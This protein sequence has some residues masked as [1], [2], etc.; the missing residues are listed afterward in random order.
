MFFCTLQVQWEYQA[1]SGLYQPYP[2]EINSNLEK[3]Q[4]AGKDHVEWEKEEPDGKVKRWMV[5]LKQMLETDGQTTKQI[6]RKVL[7]EKGKYQCK[8]RC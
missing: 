4:K 6:K 8:I 3:A 1:P 7:A 5:D 2:A